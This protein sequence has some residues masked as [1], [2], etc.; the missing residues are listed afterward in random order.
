MVQRQLQHRQ[1][2]AG[3]VL[4]AAVQQQ[5]VAELVDMA[6]GELGDQL[7][8]DADLGRGDVQAHIVAVAAQGGSLHPPPGLAA[9][10]AMVEP[11]LRGLGHRRAVAVGQI[12]VVGDQRADFHQINIGILSAR[13]QL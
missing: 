11:R 1:R 9:H 13:K 7:V 2:A 5:P 10:L 4:G 8:P 12:G 6:A 3:Q